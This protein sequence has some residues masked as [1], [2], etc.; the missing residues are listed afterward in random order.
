MVKIEK[1]SWGKVK[2]NGQVYHQVLIIGEKVLERDKEKLE[3]LFGTTHQIGD[4]EQRELLSDNPEVILIVNGWS[5]LLKIDEEFKKKVEDTG[6][7]LRVVLTSEVVKEYN[8]L[9]AEGRK[10]NC[11][12]HTTC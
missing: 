7:E 1:V 3:T 9:I 8:H 12:I 11:L 4:W 10:V 5:G 6:I 2:V